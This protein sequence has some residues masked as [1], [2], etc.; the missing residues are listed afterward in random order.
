MNIYTKQFSLS[1]KKQNFPMSFTMPNVL[2]WGSN[3]NLILINFALVVLTVVFLISYIFITNNIV[4]DG[5]RVESFKLGIN[6]SKTV[7]AS[8]GEDLS[9]DLDL[10]ELRL[11]AESNNMIEAEDREVVYM[12]NGLAK[13]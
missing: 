11:F 4:A 2:S 5:Y 7:A 12:T 6:E 1:H 10:D 3:K 13:N 9:R 8:L